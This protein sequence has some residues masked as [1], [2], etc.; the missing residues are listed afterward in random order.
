MKPR[1]TIQKSTMSAIVPYNTVSRGFEDYKV[2]GQCF[3]CQLS[4]LGFVIN[5]SYHGFP[6]AFRMS[7]PTLQYLS[8]VQTN[9]SETRCFAF[10][11]FCANDF[12][13]YSAGKYHNEKQKY[14]LPFIIFIVFVYFLCPSSESSTQGLKTLHRVLVCQVCHVCLACSAAVHLSMPIT[15]SYNKKMLAATC[16]SHL[17]LSR[18]VVKNKSRYLIRFKWEKDKGHAMKAVLPSAYL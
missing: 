11:L 5:Y 18:E 3:V 7:I 17:A 14:K 12:F 1:L 4:L 2:H 13:L 15:Y 8:T 6:E 16:L 10:L 9:Y